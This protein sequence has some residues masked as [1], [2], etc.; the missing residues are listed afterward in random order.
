MDERLKQHLTARAT[1]LRG[2][3]IVLFTIIY[4]IAEIVLVAVVVF[5]FLS[6]LVTGGTNQRLLALG[7]SLSTF[8]YQILCYVTF[9]SDTRPY[10]FDAWPKGEPVVAAPAKPK[11]RRA[12]KKAPTA[13]T[14][15]AEKG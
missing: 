7:Q 15:E 14:Q 8:V 5:Q 4:T 3:Y 9:N 10:P 2:F 12:R 1:W 13:E 6:T 11:A